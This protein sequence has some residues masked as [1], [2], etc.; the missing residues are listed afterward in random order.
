MTYEEYWGSNDP[1]R[2]REYREAERL[3]TERKNQEAW[4]QGLYF[5]NAVSVALYNAF[6]KKGSEAEHYPEKPF[7]ISGKPKPENNEPTDEERQ[8][9]RLK[10]IARLNAAKAAWH[11]ANTK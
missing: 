10:L 2:L 3:R 7:D 4:L 11:R 9:E 8:A 1:E 5:Y 6:R